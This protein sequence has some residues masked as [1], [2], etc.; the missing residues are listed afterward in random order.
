MK[1]F[2]FEAEIAFPKFSEVRDTVKIPKRSDLMIGCNIHKRRLLELIIKE[3]I[4]GCIIDPFNQMTNDYSTVGGRDDK[5]LE[6]VLGEFDRFA[7]LNQVFL[8]LWRT[9]K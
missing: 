8:S 9:R 4:D 1:K 2:H 3:K 5:Y 7:N 6:A